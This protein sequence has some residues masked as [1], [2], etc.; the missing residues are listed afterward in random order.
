MVFFLDPIYQLASIL[1]IFLH[2]FLGRQHDTGGP[3]ILILIIIG[4][5]G[6]GH[7]PQLNALTL[8]RLPLPIKTLMPLTEPLDFMPGNLE[9]GHFIETVLRAEGH[10]Q[11]QIRALVYF[12]QHNHWQGLFR[13]RYLVDLAARGSFYQNSRVKFFVCDFQAEEVVG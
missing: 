4:P 11:V 5:R 8:C 3:P 9:I 10:G 6:Q 7:L 1:H 2:D 13:D 12:R